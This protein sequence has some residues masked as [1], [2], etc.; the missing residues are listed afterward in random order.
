MTNKFTSENLEQLLRE[1]KANLA[2]E[3]IEL[4]REEE[5]LVKA[6]LLG[7]LDDQDFHIRAIELAKKASIKPKGDR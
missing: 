6:N 2:I 4:T 7:E 1:A 3:G 5:D